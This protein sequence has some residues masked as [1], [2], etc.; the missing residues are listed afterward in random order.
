M[1]ARARANYSFVAQKRRRWWSFLVNA[2]ARKLFICRSN[3][4]GWSPRSTVGQPRRSA[5]GTAV[6]VSQDDYPVCVMN[7]NASLLA[8][9][10]LS[11]IA[12]RFCTHERAQIVCQ[13]FNLWSSAA[14]VGRRDSGITEYTQIMSYEVC[15]SACQLVLSQ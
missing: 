7:T 8:Q 6:P 12:K 13:S 10:V 1:Y 15:H 14:S 2:S 9:T 5:V 3:A 4:I 11:V